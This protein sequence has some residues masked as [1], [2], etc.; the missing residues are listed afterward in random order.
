MEED[1]LEIRFGVVAVKKGFVSPDQIIDA[2]GIQTR[3]NL[4]KGKHRKIGQI[5][6]DEGVIT[7]P[8][9]DEV[10]QTLEA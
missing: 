6:V 10:L 3:E 2:M 9:R 8:Q 4:S 7:F 5:L 1:Y